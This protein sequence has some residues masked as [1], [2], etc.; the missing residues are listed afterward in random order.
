[1]S[2][3]VDTN[4]LFDVLVARAP[5]GDESEQ[6]LVNARDQ[7]IIIFSEP[8]YAELSSFFPA[9]T[10]LLRF[11]E[12]TGISLQPSGPEALHLAG[13][14]SS[15]YTHRCPVFLLCPR[16]GMAHDVRCSQCG[17]PIRT[18]QHIV[19]DFLIGAHALVHAERLLTLD[20]GYYRTYFPQLMLA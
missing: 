4:I 7:G 2:T 18:R 13:L 14:A 1:M 3:A 9:Q 15:E 5:H 11:L 20:K 10:D 12:R 17:T 19:A 6:S 16:C 8:V